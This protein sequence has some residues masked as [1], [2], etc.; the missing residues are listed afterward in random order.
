VKVLR[1]SIGFGKPLLR[2]TV[3]AD[4]TEWTI[5]PIPLGGYVALLAPE[6]RNSG[7]ILAQMGTVAMASGEWIEL[8]FDERSKLANLM[9]TPSAIQALVDNRQAVQ[10]PGGLIILSAQAA[11]RLQGGVVR[12]SGTLEAKGIVNDGGVIRITASDRIV[13]SGRISA[14]AKADATGQGGTVTLIADLSNPNSVTEVSG[15]I[16]AQGGAAG[17]R[18]GGGTAAARARGRRCVDGGRRAIPV[19]QEPERVCGGRREGLRADGEGGGEAAGQADHGQLRDCEGR[20]H[21]AVE[22]GATARIGPSGA[23][24]A[25]RGRGGRGVGAGHAGGGGRPGHLPDQRRRVGADAAAD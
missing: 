10:A 20:A 18:S 6:V 23:G 8:Q 7:I 5:S 1:F 24:P 19:G 9:V 11:S 22:A 21:A 4:R 15:S 13:H 16:S 3:G 14:D 2:F 25:R 12:N 17:G